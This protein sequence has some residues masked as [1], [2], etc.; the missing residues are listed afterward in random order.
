MPMYR[1]ADLVCSTRGRQAV[2]HKLA[3]GQ[4]RSNITR[5]NV[6][7]GGGSTVPTFVLR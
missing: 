4:I 3:T 1:L 6:T 2:Y 7:A 5:L